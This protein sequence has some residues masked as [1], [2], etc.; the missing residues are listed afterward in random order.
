[1]AS[2]D[3]GFGL[4]VGLLSRARKAAVEESLFQRSFH[5]RSAF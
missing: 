4:V 1:M 3:E 2:G 5:G